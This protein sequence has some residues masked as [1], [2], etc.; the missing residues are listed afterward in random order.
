M[1]LTAAHKRFVT[2]LTD[3][4]TTELQTRAVLVPGRAV[5]WSH[6]VE[7]IPGVMVRIETL[8]G[9]SGFERKLVALDLVRRAVLR[10]NPTPGVQAVVNAA[11]PTHIGLVSD[12][13]RIHVT[14][15]LGS[16][17]ELRPDETV[18]GTVWRKGFQ[19]DLGSTASM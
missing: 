9:L 17:A 6:I 11:L 10:R 16:E 12:A 4:L 3:H 13:I 1:D 18:F 14:R 19:T 8:K 7:S 2:E 5:Y 15:E